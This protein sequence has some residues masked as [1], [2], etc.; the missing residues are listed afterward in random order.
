MKRRGSRLSECRTLNILITLCSYL[1][2]VSGRLVFGVGLEHS[3][4][5]TWIRI[6]LEAWLCFRV[7]LCCVVY[8]KALRRADPH[9]RSSI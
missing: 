9:P 5:G 4:V 2:D 6:P 3:N 1:G 8:V 7:L